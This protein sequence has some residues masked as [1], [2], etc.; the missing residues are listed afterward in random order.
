MFITVF[1]PQGRGGPL[2]QLQ[3]RTVWAL[4]RATGRRGSGTAREGWLALA[5]PLTSVLTLVIWVVLLV[6]GFA[7]IHYPWI[8]DFLVSPG[9]L[10]VPW[11]ETLYYSGYTAATLGFGDIVPNHGVLRLLA[12]LE[13]FLGFALLSTSVTYLSSVYRELIRM[14]TL[15]A[16]IAGYFRVND[17]RLLG[18]EEPARYEALVRWGEHVSSELLYVLRAHQQY[19]I[20]HYFYAAQRQQALPVQLGHLLALRQA[21]RDDELQAPAATLA[22]NPSFRALRGSVEDYLQEVDSH[23]VPKSFRSGT[24]DADKTER[25]HRALLEYMCYVPVDP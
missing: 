10:R 9:T 21:V 3:N 16:N 25:A 14:Q 7:L 5:G 2:N 8:R 4:F 1:H 13:A 15:A 11:A 19:P 22:D 17:P 20:L 24:H 6:I 12:P 23:F 18:R